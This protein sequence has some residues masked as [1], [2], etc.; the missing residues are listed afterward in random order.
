[1]KRAITYIILLIALILMLLLLCG[2]QNAVKKILKEAIK[3]PLKEAPLAEKR[4]YVMRLPQPGEKRNEYNYSIYIIKADASGNT[5]WI[6]TYTTGNN[7]WAEAV[8]PLDDGGTLIAARS[9]SSEEGYLGMYLLKVG[10]G[11]EKISVTWF[12]E[13]KEGDFKEKSGDCI[14]TAGRAYSGGA[15][16]GAYLAGTGKDGNY[17]WVRNFGAGYFDWGYTSIWV[18]EG[19]F[20]TIAQDD[21]PSTGNGDFVIAQRDSHGKYDWSRR[22]GGDKFD[23]GYSIEPVK[24]GGFIAAGLTYSFGAGNDDA[25]IIRLNDDG[26]KIWEKYYGKAG[27]DRAYDAVE[28]ADNGFL[29]AGTTDSI[30]AGGYD[31]Y[32]IKMDSDGNIKWQKTYGGAH[33]DTAHA[34]AAT[35]D[36]G[37]IAVGATDSFQPVKI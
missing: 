32:F 26:Q 36:G 13:I 24:S 16:G 6:R 19:H 7:D 33:D 12:N 25:Y 11:G 23:R 8:Y 27:H 2:R 1:M 37:F 4:D 22:F 17:K 21:E 34:V 18:G 29:A 31:A 9:Y 28:T 10:P 35:K 3:A 20:V 14:I 5:Q 15:S 30:G